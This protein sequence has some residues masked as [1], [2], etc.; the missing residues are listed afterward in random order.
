[1]PIPFND[2]F[3]TTANAFILDSQDIKA[4]LK[5]VVATVADL[6]QYQTFKSN[7]VED[8]SLLVYVQGGNGADGNSAQGFWFYDTVAA[9]GVAQEND[10]GWVRFDGL[11]TGAGGGLALRDKLRQPL[12]LLPTLT[13]L[14]TYS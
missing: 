11:I 9:G 10:W 13:K 6:E 2:S 3:V 7:I 5:R 4:G 12:F 1:M 14:P 8:Q